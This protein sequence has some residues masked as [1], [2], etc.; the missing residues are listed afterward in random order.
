MLKQ[1]N[2]KRR[3]E[4][5]HVGDR[6]LL[7]TKHPWFQNTADGFTIDR[8]GRLGKANERQTKDK[9]RQSTQ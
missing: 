5:F 1:A 2:A 9:G 6:V 4:D 7:S 3:D 8:A